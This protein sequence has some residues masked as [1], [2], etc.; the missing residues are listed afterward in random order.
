MKVVLIPCGSTEWDDEGRLLGRVELSLNETGEQQC[1]HWVDSLNGLNL[2]RIL[3]APDG[4]AT[5]TA[6]II[7]RRLS[8]PTKPLDD[9]SE[10]D[11]GLWAGLTKSELKTRYSRAHR[12][13]S[14]SPLNVNPP[15][16]ESFSDAA[17]RLGTCIRKQLKKKNGNN[18]IGVVVRPFTFEMIRCVLQGHDLSNAWESTNRASEPVV[19]ERG[20]KAPAAAE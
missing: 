15:G 14:E 5:Q 2:E 4:L 20:P 10:V 3:H 1:A 18:A 17:E 16:G 8:V 9:L 13:L 12:Q 7:A 19:I 11:I 6:K